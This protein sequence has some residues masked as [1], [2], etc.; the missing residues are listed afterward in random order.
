MLM[1]RI[2]GWDSV[3]AEMQGRTSLH[4]RTH[5]PPYRIRRC[6]FGHSQRDQF[7]LSGRLQRSDDRGWFFGGSARW[8][9]EQRHRHRVL[10]SGHV[11]PGVALHAGHRPVLVHRV[12]LLVRRVKEQPA[13][14]R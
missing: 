12:G 9:D 4:G 11:Q 7:S 6:P 13:D 10:R 8:R 3:S 5:S 1:D 2:G 14:A